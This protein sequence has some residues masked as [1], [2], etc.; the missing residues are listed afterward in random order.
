MK[1]ILTV[2]A[3][4]AALAAGTARAEKEPPSGGPDAAGKGKLELSEEQQKKLKAA[5]REHRDA[6]MAIRGERQAALRK[7]R[8][9]LE[10]GAPDSELS[11]TLDRLTKARRDLRAE[12]DKL[13]DKLKS[14]L[15]VKQRAKLAARLR[16]A[17]GL[18]GHMGGPRGRG[19]P[20]HKPDHKPE[21]AGEDADDD[22][23]GEDD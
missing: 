21:P 9:Q 6:A 23:P 13:E 8:D 1:N 12:Q 17:V 11:A 15:D 2:F 5:R 3:L 7:L 19:R 4:A 22:E 20:D 18:R 16:R 10:D 14:I